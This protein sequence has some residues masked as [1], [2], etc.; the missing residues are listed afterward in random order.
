VITGLVFLLSGCSETQ[1]ENSTLSILWQTGRAVGII[2]P[3]DKV[4]H[5]EP[6]SIHSH[7]HVYRIKD[8]THSPIL[9]VFRLLGDEFVF[10]P[11]I[12][13][14]P[15]TGYSIALD[16]QSLGEIE[17]PNADE[18]NPPEVLSIYPRADTLPENLL[19]VY[20]KFSKPMQE[21]EALQHLV[22]LRN[23]QDTLKDIFLD[24]Q[25]EL[26]NNDRSVLTLWLDPG[27]IKRGL[28][29]NEVLGQPLVK[30]NRYSL[31][32]DQDWKDTYGVSM[33]QGY[34]KDFLSWQRDSISPDIETW[35]LHLPVAA[36]REPMLVD[37]HEPLDYILLTN[38]LRILD[39]NGKVVTGQ[40][41]VLDDERK[42]QFI[43]D[44]KWQVGEYTLESES[45]LED[46][47]GN[48]LN[49]LFDSN[50]EQRKNDEGRKIFKTV[51]TIK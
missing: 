34:R 24:L 16:E 8:S 27:R 45:R 21:G 6:D 39:H 26:W 33:A 44:S 19:K 5:I 43:P 48:N 15:G 36:T 2:I 41:S 13:L 47:A 11:L 10:E 31:L 37:F 18:K 29:P 40:V 9:G 51:F 4:N 25:P 17:I 12:P 22:L 23:N 28:Q 7:L 1:K 32:V 49:R 35:K 38:C 20:I 14:T 46:L 50:V 42:L 3:L 30:G